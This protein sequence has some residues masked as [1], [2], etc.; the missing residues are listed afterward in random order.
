M[1][2]ENPTDPK[3][4]SFPRAVTLDGFQEIVGASRLKPAARQRSRQR[5]QHGVEEALIEADYQSDEK[6]HSAEGS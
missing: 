6:S 5:F 4:G 1:T 2:A 3:P